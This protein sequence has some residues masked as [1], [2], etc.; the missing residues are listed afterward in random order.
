MKQSRFLMCPPTHFDVEYVINPWMEGR[1]NTANTELAAAQWSSFHN[2]MA[3][4]A[5]VSLMPPVDGLPDLVFTA[6]AALVHRDS[7]VLSS[8]RHPE[9]QPES[10]HYS[11]WLTADGFNVRILPDGIRFEGAGDALIDRGR[12]LLWFGHGFRSDLAAKPFLERW[13]G[14]EVQPLR[15][16][17]NRF[18]HLDTCFCPLDEGLLIYFPEAFDEASRSAIESRVPADQRFALSDSEAVTFA[19]NAVNVGKTV[20]LNHP[21]PETAAWLTSRGFDVVP[22]GVSEFMK[23]GGATKCLSLRLDEA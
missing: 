17:D 13:T 19:C 3:G 2:L 14:L 20:I 22:S 7:A 10:R 5:D 18:Y 9:R 4:V 16:R 1:I 21:S 12:P 15:L 8:F 6:N 23:A 11:D